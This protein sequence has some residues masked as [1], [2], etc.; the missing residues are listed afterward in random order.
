MT[1][2]LAHMD[3]MGIGMMMGFYLWLE[4]GYP[5]SFE[6]F[7]YGDVHGQTIDLRD[8]DLFN[9]KASGFEWK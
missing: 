8:R 2:P 4:S 9:L 1:G 3:D 5:A 6:G 7:Q